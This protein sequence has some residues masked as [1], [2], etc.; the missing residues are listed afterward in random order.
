MWNCAASVKTLAVFH[1]SA[2]LIWHSAT[3]F[4][5]L[6]F[7][8]C[9]CLLLKKKEKKKENGFARISCTT[10]CAN[11][12]FQDHFSSV[13]KCYTTSIRQYL[14]LYVSG[15]VCGIVQKFARRQQMQPEELN[16][17]HQP[18]NCSSSTHT[19]RVWYLT[20]LA[21]YQVVESKPP[22]SSTCLSFLMLSAI[23][24]MSWMIYNE[25]MDVIKKKY[26]EEYFF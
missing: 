5:V 11:I 4:I 12:Y 13:L 22:I 3:C 15:A 23:W 2:V 14:A 19:P 21:T 6:F 17:R 25:C 9:I 16:K 10:L 18:A 1:C 7:V 26:C 20:P 24:S 8:F